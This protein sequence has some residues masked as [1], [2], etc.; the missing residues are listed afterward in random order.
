VTGVL[1]LS[2]SVVRRRNSSVQPLIASKC[3]YNGA[4]CILTSRKTS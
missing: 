1:K 3:S 4:A 2:S